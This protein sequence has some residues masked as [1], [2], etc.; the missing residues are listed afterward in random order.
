MSSTADEAMLARTREAVPLGLLAVLAFLVTRAAMLAIPPFAADTHLYFE[1]AREL[2]TGAR[3]YLDV[4]LEYPP[5]ALVLFV[6]PLWWPGA[7]ESYAVYR[8]VFAGEMLLCDALAFALVAWVCRREQRGAMPLFAY[9]VFGALLQPLLFDRF[10]IA[11]GAAMTAALVLARRGGEI[12]RIASWLALAAGC[13]LK[14]TP[15]VL[16]PMLLLLTA[17]EVS[18]RRRIGEWL[19]GFALPI[20]LVV[21][22]RPDSLLAPLSYHRARGVQIE[23]VWASVALATQWLGGTLDVRHE[24]GAEHL[25]GAAVELLLPLIRPVMAAAIVVATMRALRRRDLFAGG[26]GVLLALLATA[27]VLSPQFFLWLVP[28]VPLA[29]RDL[30]L[31]FLLALFLT[32]VLFRLESWRLVSLQAGGIALLGVRNLVLVWIAWRALRARES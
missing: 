24:F 12:A 2:A 32:S 21:L 7:G 20:A 1:R 17:S 16:A 9:V 22:W 27:N 31:P 15:L 23:S 8:A 6:L 18:W 13:L 14:L 11:V 19:V 5:L 28:L 25:H 4:P 30:W 3:A 29:R 26:A 10:D